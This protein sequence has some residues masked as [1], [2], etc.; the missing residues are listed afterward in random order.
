MARTDTAPETT[1]NGVVEIKMAD[2]TKRTLTLNLPD[3]LR[4]KIDGDATTRDVAANAVAREILASHYGMRIIDTP[5][6]IVVPGLSKE[7]RAKVRKLEQTQKRETTNAIMD[8][9]LSGTIPKDAL[10]KYGLGHLVPKTTAEL[11]AVVKSKE[12]T[13]AGAP[14]EVAA[15]A[16]A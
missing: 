7:E 1:S 12:L 9:I 8:A 10:E 13:A 14:A 16:P 15:G 11:V 5:R 2:A 3:E 4:A 6:A